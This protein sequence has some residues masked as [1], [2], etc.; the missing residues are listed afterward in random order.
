MTKIAIVRGLN[1]NRG[2]TLPEG[3]PF[4]NWSMLTAGEMDMTLAKHNLWLR[5]Y[6]MPEKEKTW[7]KGAKLIDKYLSNGVHGTTPYLPYIPTDL[8]FVAKAIK[9]AHRKIAPAGELLIRSSRDMSRGID[10]EMVAGVH[11]EELIKSDM[12]SL[13]KAFPHCFRVTNLGQAGQSGW[14]PTYEMLSSC[15]KLID[16]ITELNNN[17]PKGAHHLL[18]EFIDN[19]NA[20]KWTTTVAVKAVNHAGAVDIL[21]KTTEIERAQLKAWMRNAI[22]FRNGKAN[23]GYI[24]P[25]QTIEG[26]RVNPKLDIKAFEYDTEDSIGFLDPVTITV[27]AKLLMLALSAFVAIKSASEKNYDV[28]FQALRNIGE[29][30]FSANGTD[31][32]TD[33]TGGGNDDEDD[34]GGEGDEDKDPIDPPKD[35]PKKPAKKSIGDMIKENPVPAALIGGGL[36]WSLSK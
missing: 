9:N 30:T 7:V 31:F 20:K 34:N 10:I 12:E 27:I 36:F 21:K 35:P 33:N 24:T 26:L 17:L 18:Y 23:K 11:G 28:S 13:Q 19:P 2:R 6:L 8:N 4:L 5:H 22:I 29:L 32:K 16:F 3:M 14:K 15:R 1:D 25:E